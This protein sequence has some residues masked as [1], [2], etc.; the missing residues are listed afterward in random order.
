MTSNHD[1]H[2]RGLA[3]LRRIHGGHAGEALVA[4]QREICPDFATMTID[5]ALAG[6]MARPHLD[7]KTRQLVVVA[8]CTTLGH[9]HPQLRAHIEGA[10]SV[11]ATK[12]EIVETILQTLFYAGGAAVA[13]ALQIAKD[14]LA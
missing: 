2:E 5:W 7:L 9:A 3:L 11:G 12:D 4:A 13:N 14:A 8:A 1:E 6:I 10:V